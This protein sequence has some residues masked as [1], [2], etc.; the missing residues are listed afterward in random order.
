MSEIINVMLNV[1]F[2]AGEDKEF[3]MHQMQLPKCF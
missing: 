2:L 3:N 1:L